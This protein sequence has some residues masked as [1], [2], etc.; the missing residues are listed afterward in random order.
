MSNKDIIINSNYDID[1]KI[2]AFIMTIANEMQVAT[3]KVLKKYDL[4]KTQ[5]DILHCLQFAEQKMLTVKQIKE[6]LVEESPNVSRSLNKLMENG[7]IEKERT[8]EDQRVV[9]VYITSKGKKVHY[10]ADMA[11]LEEG[12]GLSLN[13]SEKEILYNLLQKV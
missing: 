8:L 3:A 7:Y 12:K 1:T 4:S 5:L 10:E 2:F 11:I 9:K 13:N 6:Q